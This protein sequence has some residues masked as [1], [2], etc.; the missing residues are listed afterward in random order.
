[1]FCIFTQ[2]Y[3]KR[4]NKYQ[5][6]NFTKIIFWVNTNSAKS[7]NSLVDQVRR[8]KNMVGGSDISP[9]LYEFKF[10][11][12]SGNKVITLIVILKTSV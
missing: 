4:L 5:A 1:M 2:I 7:S 3:C 10:I 6:R 9:H 11:S 12:C 8:I